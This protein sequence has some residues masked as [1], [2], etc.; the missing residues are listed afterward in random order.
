MNVSF[1]HERDEY[2]SVRF[3]NYSAKSIVYVYRVLSG[4]FFLLI[5]ETLTLSLHFYVNLIVR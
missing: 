3:L 5:W 1:D 2:I 4:P